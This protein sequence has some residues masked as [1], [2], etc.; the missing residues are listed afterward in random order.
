MANGM[1]VNLSQLGQC[2]A[3]P[4]ANHSPI[5]DHN[6]CGDALIGHLTSPTP[7]P[8]SSLPSPCNQSDVTSNHLSWLIR[9]QLFLNLCPITLQQLFSVATPLPLPATF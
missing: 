2:P 7:L 9:D 5:L 6:R 1:W 8:L 4:R 3:S